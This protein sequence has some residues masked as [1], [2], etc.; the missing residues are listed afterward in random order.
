MS[1]FKLRGQLSSQVT[2]GNNHP[3]AVLFLYCSHAGTISVSHKDVPSNASFHTSSF[4]S[5]ECPF[6]IYPLQFA[7]A[8]FYFFSSQY[9]L[10]PTSDQTL[11]L[12]QCHC[13]L[14][15]GLATLPRL[16]RRFGGQ[17]PWMT[18]S[19]IHTIWKTVSSVHS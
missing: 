3:V 5:L 19:S 12:H 2:L 14:G 1:K 18:I 7:S 13:E 6:S 15:G 11:H 8:L 10:P 16:V 17:L 9:N 4:L